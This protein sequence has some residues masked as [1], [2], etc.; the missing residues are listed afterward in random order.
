[1]KVLPP[2]PVFRSM[3]GTAF[4]AWAVLRAI[5]LGLQIDPTIAIVWTFS[6]S[7]AL[8]WVEIHRRGLRLFL[9]SLGVPRRS[10]MASAGLVLVGIELV[11]QVGLMLGRLR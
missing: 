4:I 11:L 6:V 1:V 9:L 10:V 5:T 3:A 8:L 2:G 7:M